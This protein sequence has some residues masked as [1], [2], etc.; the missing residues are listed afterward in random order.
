MNRSRLLGVT[1]A[2]L[3][4][5]SA[6]AGLT[7]NAM[8]AGS[9]TGAGSTLVAPLMTSWTQDF[10]NKHDINVTYGAVG[11]GAGIAQVTARTVDFGASDAPLN[12]SQAAA[13]NGCVQIPWA[14]TATGIAYR[15]NGVRNLRLTGKIIS[16]IYQGAITKWNDKSIKKINPKLKLPNLTITP[17]YRSDGSGDT[18]AFTDF[19]SRVDAGWKSRIGNATAVSFPKGVGGKGNDGVTAVV[20]ST[21]GSI[22]YISASYIIAHHLNTALL[23]NRAGKF[24]YPNLANIKAAAAAVKS[25]PANNELHIVDPP[26]KYKTAYPLSTFTYA[27]VP[28]VSKQAGAVRLFVLY[29]MSGAGQSFGPA[30][31]FSPIPGVVYKAAVAATSQLQQG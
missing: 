5:T 24:E 3:V 10:A 31:D 6:S 19:L 14:L 18:Y 28:K 9:L 27:I 13:C 2:A 29:A 30:L 26:A 23:Q 8:A 15:L 25:V 20:S 12:P 1:V 22:G 11:S 16:R 4:T 7:A 21:N 17:V